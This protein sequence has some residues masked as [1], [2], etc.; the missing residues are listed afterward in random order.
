MHTYSNL[1]RKPTHDNVKKLVNL[2]T[3]LNK[4]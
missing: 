4:T 1:T 2:E 3:K